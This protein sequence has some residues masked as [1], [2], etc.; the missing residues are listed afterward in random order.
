VHRALAVD[1]LE[2]RL[3][4]LDVVADGIDHGL[5]A[6]QC[7]THRRLVPYIGVDRGDLPSL[8]GLCEE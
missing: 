8:A 6:I 2:G 4:S 3:A 5:G 7:R 1:R